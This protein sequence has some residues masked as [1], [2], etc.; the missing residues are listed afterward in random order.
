MQLPITSSS[1]EVDTETEVEL[2]A[3]TY[4]PIEED[5]EDTDTA[6]AQH[7]TPT[8]PKKARF[9]R[10]RKE[11]VTE[12]ISVLLDRCNISDRNAVR[13]ISATAE[14]LGENIAMLA[15]SRSTVRN[16]R[17]QFR[18]ERAA[19]IKSLFQNS[20]FE[21]AVLHWDGK[22]L[23]DLLKKDKVDRIAILV[24]CG[25]EEQLIGVPGLEN[26]KGNTQ[27]RAI[28]TEVNDWGLI[29]R[30]E[31]MCFDTTS[32]NT[33]CW[34]G[35]CT[36]LEQLFD[37]ELL[38]LACRHHILEIMLKSIFD[39]VMGS[40]TAPHPDIFNRFSKAWSAIDKGNF[41]TVID[42]PEVE[43]DENEANEITSFLLQQLHTSHN[44]PRDDYK[45]FL[46]LS[47]VFLGCLHPDLLNFKSPGAIHH[48]RWMAKGIYCLKMFIFKSQF[49]MT[50]VE[51]DGIRRICVFIVKIYVKAWFKCTE[52]TLAPNLDFE[53]MKSLISYKKIDEVIANAAL[54]KLLNHLW[55]LNPEQVTFAF[56]DETLDNE[57]KRNMASKLLSLEHQNQEHEEERIVRFTITQADVDLFTNRNL[58]YFL[59]ARSLNLFTRVGITTAFLHT[60]PEDWDKHEDYQKARNFVKRLRVVNDTAERGVKL[61]ADF[62]NHLKDEDQQQFLLHVASE[63]RKLYPDVLKETLAKQ[64]PH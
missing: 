61:I 53:M 58:D 21:G 35:V 41:K 23:P 24:S 10:G 16:R 33:G 26:S 64:L 43:F 15:V 2:E 14:A 17:K 51:H 42:D 31:G 39:C 50:D 57:V 27:A 1:S 52:A 20:K 44:L 13:I 62:N 32:V 9:S 11:I 5:N 48:A 8:Q 54:S 36:F 4:N 30:I 6:R 19:V 18:S 22:L 46:Q 49:R 37:K 45:E 40:T 60:N 28:F 47:L 29:S 38:Y 59:S 56:F 34:N 63:C 7:E 12:K 55:Y 3:D 25:G